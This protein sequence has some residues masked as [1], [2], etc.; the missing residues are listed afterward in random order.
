MSNVIKH[1]YEFMFLFDCENGNPNGDPDAGNSPRIDPQ[2][3]RG[4]VSDVAIKR[5]IR[6]YVQIIHENE[7][8]NA[9][10]VENAT[11]L[12]TKIAIAHEQANGRLPDAGKKASKVEVVSARDWMCKHFYDVRTFGAVMST[13]PNAGQVRGP[14]QIAFAKSEHSI[15]PLDISMTR[16]AVAEDLKKAKSSDVDMFGKYFNAMLE[17]GVYLAPSQFEAGF[18]STAHSQSEIENTIAAATEIFQSW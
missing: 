4:L 6:N 11:N 7:S 15:I 12:N 8:P 9:I 3:M 10:F 5:R 18:I 13:G 17:K 16:M 1:R 14:V 2:D